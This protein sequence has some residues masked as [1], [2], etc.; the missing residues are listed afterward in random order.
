MRLITARTVAEENAATALRAKRTEML[1]RLGGIANAIWVPLSALEG[2]QLQDL[3][4]GK[5]LMKRS[6]QKRQSASA[7]AGTPEMLNVMKTV[8]S[9]TK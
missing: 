1:D 9:V 2:M 3:G 5:G 4:L 8:V 7:A 6:L